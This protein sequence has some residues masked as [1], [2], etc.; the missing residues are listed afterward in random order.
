MN[1]KQRTLG[2]ADQAL[3]DLQYTAVEPDGSSSERLDP[4]TDRFSTLTLGSLQNADA[5]AQGDEAFVD[6]AGKTKGKAGEALEPYD[7]VRV[8]TGGKWFKAK[9]GDTVSGLYLG[10]TTGSA[11]LRADYS[12]RFPPH[13]F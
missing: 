5:D 10:K 11:T 9:S 13:P 1:Y 6:V 2:F 3:S 7:E 8:G 4:S 12:P